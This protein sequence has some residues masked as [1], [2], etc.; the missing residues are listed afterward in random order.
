MFH[1]ELKKG[2]LATLKQRIIPTKNLD[3]KIRNSYIQ[4][5]VKQQYANQ[6]IMYLC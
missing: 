4:A 1:I 6:D 2:T 3:K 5:K